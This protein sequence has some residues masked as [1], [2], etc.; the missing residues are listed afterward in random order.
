MKNGTFEEMISSL[1]TKGIYLTSLTQE[2][3]G[4]TWLVSFRK[5][6]YW[7][8]SYGA[9]KT[10]KEAFKNGVEKLAEQLS[11]KDWAEIKNPPKKAK[12]KARRGRV[13]L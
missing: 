1:N 3:N 4:K 13:K 2:N 7:S 11:E 10:L 6:G 9:G 12:G 8:A 5:K